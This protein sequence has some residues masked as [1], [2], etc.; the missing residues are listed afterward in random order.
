MTTSFTVGSLTVAVLHDGEFL[1]APTFLDGPID[2]GTDQIDDAGRARLPIN[3]FLVSDGGRNILID[4]GIGPDPDATLDA[5]SARFGIARASMSLS[6]SAG[7]ARDLREW[8]V[9]VDDID[10][11]VVSHLHLDH[12]GWLT[13]IHGTPC[14]PRASMMLPRNDFDHFIRNGHSTLP[15]AKVESLR[16]LEASGRVELID[17][18]HAISRSVTAIAAPGHTPGHTVF[19]IADGKDRALVLGDSMYCPAQLSEVEVGAL[20]DMDPMLARRT[21]EM[22]ARDAEAHGSQAIGCHFAGGRTARVENGR[23]V[24]E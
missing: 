4:A 7:L 10:T 24:V 8:G 18:G 22:I 20:H 2:P 23:A 12:V 17:D 11:V 19:A 15:T 21:R 5:L 13:D 1:M 16:N 3:A 6:G 14:F 9:G